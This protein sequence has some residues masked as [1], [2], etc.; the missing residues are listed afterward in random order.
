MTCGPIGLIWI[1][2]RC[3]GRSGI[4]G[5]IENVARREDRG[6]DGRDRFDVVT[7]GAQQHAAQP[8]TVAV[9]LE[10]DGPAH[11]VGQR[12]GRTDPVGGGDTDRLIGLPLMGDVQPGRKAPVPGTRERRRW[13]EDRSTMAQ[14][15][16]VPGTAALAIRGSLLALANRSDAIALHTA[17]DALLAG[18]NAVHKHRDAA[19]VHGRCVRAASVRP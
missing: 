6:L 5:T 2:R 17:V 12:L 3:D 10:A 16:D 15:T 4:M 7:C 1:R 8:R 19:Q 11:A 14:P 9:L 18:V 13:R